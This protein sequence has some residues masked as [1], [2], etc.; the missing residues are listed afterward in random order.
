MRY[1]DTLFFQSPSQPCPLNR[2]AHGLTSRFILEAL[3]SIGARRDRRHLPLQ[4]LP[5]RWSGAAARHDA[6]TARVHPP[7]PAPCPAT[8]LPPHSPL[9]PARQFRPQGEYSASPRTACGGT[10]AGACRSAR[11]IRLAPT[12]S[13]LRR[14]HDHRRDLRAMAAT[15][16]ATS[17]PRT[18]REQPVVTRHSLYSPPAATPKLRRMPPGTPFATIGATRLD[19]S[20]GQFPMNGPSGEKSHSPSPANAGAEPDPE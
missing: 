20:S 14:A 1:R 15:T 17:R 13:L 19:I 8:W 6:R 16:R 10:A 2:V 4:R 18:N 11:T 7:L 9:R 5:P 12:L 3:G